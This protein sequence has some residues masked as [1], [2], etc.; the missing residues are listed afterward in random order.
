MCCICHYGIEIFRQLL[1]GIEHHITNP[2]VD[3]RLVALRLA[4]CVSQKVNKDGS[5][6]KFDVRQLAL[7]FHVE[8]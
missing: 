7:C 4:E 2:M 1:Q 3:Q 5:P 6:L 8:N